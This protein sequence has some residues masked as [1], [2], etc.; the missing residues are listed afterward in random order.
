MSKIYTKFPPSHVAKP[1]VFTF[2]FFL[3]Q[4]LTDYRGDIV[5]YTLNYALFD[6]IVYVLYQTQYRFGDKEKKD[7]NFNCIEISSLKKA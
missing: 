7:S 5:Y 1:L 2:W 6:T 4:K 3:L